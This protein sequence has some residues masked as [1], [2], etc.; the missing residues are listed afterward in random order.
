MDLL[1]TDT[2]LELCRQYLDEQTHRSLFFLNAHCFNIS[3]KNCDYLDALNNTDLLLNDGIGIKIASRMTGSAVRENMNGTDFIPKLLGLAADQKHKVF[4]LGGKKGIAE[5]AEANIRKHTPHIDIVGTASGYFDHD[6]EQNLIQA[7]NDSEA[8]VLVVG[9][10]VPYQELWLSRHKPLLEG[11]RISVAGGAILDF[12]ANN[13]PR[14]PQWMRRLGMEW[15][16]RFIQEPRRLFRRY[17]IGNFLF[18]YHL[19]AFILRR[20]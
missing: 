15:L 4:L 6:E 12:M 14:A 5:T 7:I 2:A 9:M 20:R 17:F 11:I 18:F 19:L 3:L 10:G 13:V 8:T 1:T 16:F